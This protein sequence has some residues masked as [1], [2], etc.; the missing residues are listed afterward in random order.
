MSAPST[1][2][3][4]DAPARE[5]MGCRF[6]RLRAFGFRAAPA[7]TLVPTMTDAT[8]AAGW[9]GLTRRVDA[10]LIRTGTEAFYGY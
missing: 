6:S 4:R 2:L 3:W 9:T 8:A 5:T 1:L 10:Q 7:F